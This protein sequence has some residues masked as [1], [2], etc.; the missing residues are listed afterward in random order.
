MN[1]KKTTVKIL[2]DLTALPDTVRGGA[3]TIGNFDGV[4]HGHVKIVNRLL[5]RATDVKGPA[6]VFTFDPHP[7]RIREKL[8]QF[9]Q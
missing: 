9:L 1:S 2:R 5:E 8:H 6:V 7:V 4:H 3:V